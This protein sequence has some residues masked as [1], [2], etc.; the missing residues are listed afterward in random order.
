VNLM[1]LI[2]LML[3]NTIILN[4]VEKIYWKK[5]EAW[6]LEAPRCFPTGWNRDNHLGNGIGGYANTYK[7][8]LPT[9]LQL[10]NDVLLDDTRTGK[11]A[12]TKIA[13][14][15]LRLRYN[16]STGDFH[17]G[18]EYTGLNYENGGYAD[19]TMNGANSPVT[20]DPYVLFGKKYESADKDW[21]LRL[22]ID[23]SQFARTFQDR[24]HTFYI[25]NLPAGHFGPIYNLM[26]R[27]KRGNVVQ[28]YP[29]VEYDFT[30]N[31][32]NVNLGD[33]IHFQWT[34]CD[35]NPQGN[36]GEGIDQT[37]RSNVVLIKDG[38]TGNGRPNYPKLL[39]K[40]DMFG[41]A[42]TKEAMDKSFEMAFINQ[43]KL[44]QCGSQTDTDCCLTKEQ[45]DQKHQNDGQK[46]DDPQNCFILNGK[47]AN[48]Y[49]GGLVKMIKTGNFNYMSTRNNNFTNRSQKG[50]INVSA[51]L[52]PVAL[53]ATV[54]GAAGFCAAAV[55]A[56]GS[57]YAASHPGSAAANCFANVKA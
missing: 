45:L 14:C 20:Q 54:V 50:I 43:Y 16:I 47:N 19:A 23:T 7:W 10:G 3:N 31:Q 9:I 37:D 25:T 22:A 29:A 27:G 57:W 28:T 24:S 4:N 40:Q 48:Y 36:D 15:V 5:V 49:D 44:T 11:P 1:K 26:V 38:D 42:A 41:D 33:F 53:A 12:G 30:P 17:G 13:P 46:E 56:G 55:I 2:L 8:V 35:T 34:G 52:S 6:N 21:Y 18:V 51:A 39:N 32:L